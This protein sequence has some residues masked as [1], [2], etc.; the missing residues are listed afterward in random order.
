MFFTKVAEASS[1]TEFVGKINGRIIN[2]LIELLFALAVVFFLYGVFE[3]LSNQ[4]NEEKRTA[5]KK[6]MIWG[7]V[8]MTI[9]MGVFMIMGLMLRTLGISDVEISPTGD[10]RIN[11]S[12]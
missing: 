12:L 5:G 8:G 9:M 4:E 6:H 2:P 10:T 1:L 7:I 11:L 3:F